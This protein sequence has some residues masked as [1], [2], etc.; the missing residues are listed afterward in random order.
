MDEK[1]FV[2]SHVELALLCRIQHA[3]HNWQTWLNSFR[4]SII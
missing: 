2:L 3:A 4:I 1:F